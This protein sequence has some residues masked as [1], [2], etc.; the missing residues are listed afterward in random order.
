MEES[1][2][3]ECFEVVSAV[4]E[5]VGLDCCRNCIL[6]SKGL[7]DF[8]LKFL[9]NLICEVYNDS[10]E[11]EKPIWLTTVCSRCVD[12]LKEGLNNFEN[13]FFCFIIQLFH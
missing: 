10:F 9:F 11:I 8:S 6:N 3:E 5:L 12:E 2:E 1:S 7:I 13:L 4:R